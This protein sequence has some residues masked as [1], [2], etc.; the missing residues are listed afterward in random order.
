MKFFSSL[1]LGAALLLAATAGFAQGEPHPA[2]LHALSDLRA[3]RWM[4]EHR[5]GDWARLD[6]EVVAVRE[7]DA[8]IS[9]IKKASIDDG[10]DL[11]DHPAVD[12]KN[13]HKGRLHDAED[14]L[15]KARADISETED[16]GF[17]HGLRNRAWKHIDEAIKFTRRAIKA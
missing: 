10:K 13:D 7:I 9:E 15:K 5:P 8:A 12:E 11:N 6:D 14:L 17:A 16:N 3:A 1:F 2:Y 4:I